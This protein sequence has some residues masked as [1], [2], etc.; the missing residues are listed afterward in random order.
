M[1]DG[2]RRGA[3]G[4]ELKIRHMT[5]LCAAIVHKFGY[6]GEP[7]NRRQYSSW[8]I[9]DNTNELMFVKKEKR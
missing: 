9:F 4:E 1:V 5:Y 8:L 7:K 3:H 2:R 6:G